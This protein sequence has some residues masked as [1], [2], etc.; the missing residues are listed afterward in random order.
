MSRL[1]DDLLLLAR[2]DA[3]RPLVHEPVDLTKLAVE[4]TSDAR[5]AAS[6]HHWRLD[7]PAEPAVVTRRSEESQS[8]LR[9]GAP[10]GVGR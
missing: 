6:G 2:L 8:E 3:G 5:V 10:A 9:A 4:A 7:L 1:V